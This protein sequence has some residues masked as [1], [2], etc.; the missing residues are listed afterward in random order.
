MAGCPLDAMALIGIGLRTLSMT[1]A[2]IG[3]VKAMIRS[4]S[5]MEL[6]RYFTS[7][8]T[9]FEGNLREKLNKFAA[10]HDVVL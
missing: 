5:V 7:Q 10:K 4:L 9:V 8:Q 6:E 3:P 1:S 2:S